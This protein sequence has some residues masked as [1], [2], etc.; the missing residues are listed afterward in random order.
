MTPFYIQWWAKV[1]CTT[2]FK[3]YCPLFERFLYYIKKPNTPFYSA[4]HSL[5]NGVQFL[6][7]NFLL[8]SEI[9]DFFLLT[10]FLLGQKFLVFIL[11]SLFLLLLLYFVK[12]II[13]KR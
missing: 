10:Y 5:L 2:F 3:T 6:H 4:E 7:I 11:C 1:S 12:S 8:W 13:A 9:V